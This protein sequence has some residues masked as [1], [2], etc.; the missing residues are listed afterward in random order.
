MT[1]IS[2]GTGSFVAKLATNRIGDKSVFWDLFGYAPAIIIFSL[3]SYKWKGVTDLDKTGVGLAVLAGVIGS[4]GLIGFYMV[5]S[6]KDASAAVPLT[7]LYP[8]LTAVLAFIFLSEKL[9]AVKVIGISLSV[10]ALFLLSL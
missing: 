10:I 1:L 7:A 5:L 8:A 9:T 3:L 6:R 2:W 4:F